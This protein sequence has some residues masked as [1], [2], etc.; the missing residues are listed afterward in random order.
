MKKVVSLLIC[1][2]LYFISANAQVDLRNLLTENLINPVGLD[3]SKPRFSWQL[4][5][6]QRNVSQTAYQI[7]VVNGKTTVW[8]SGKVTSDQS[9]HVP[10]AGNALQSGK[11][12]NWQVMVW[13]NSGKPSDW[14]MRASFQMALMNKSDWKA[15]WINAGFSEDSVNR[16]EIYFRK[17][18]SSNKNIA[19]A[20]AYITAHG[21][22]EAQ[23]NGK[24]IGD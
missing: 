9:V 24:R 2:Q 14:S 22:Y 19:S 11:K 6:Y 8:N 18:F 3:I 13:D 7:K 23:I 4:V 21:M 20:I 16:P 17:E 1:L 12:Y 15:R 10:Y 5:G